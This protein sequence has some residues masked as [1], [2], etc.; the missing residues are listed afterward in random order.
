MVIV[1]YIKRGLINSLVVEQGCLD[2]I[3][4]LR[5]A[6]SFNQLSSAIAAASSPG[7]ADTIDTRAR[8]ESVADITI[9]CLED[10]ARN[11]TEA[12]KVRWANRPGKVR[13]GERR[14]EIN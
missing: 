6:V 14:G 2:S 4:V 9:S 1:D 10:I 13:C 8:P 5:V 12:S 3:A 7:E 11:V